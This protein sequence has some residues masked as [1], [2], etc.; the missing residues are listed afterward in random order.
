MQKVRGYLMSQ[1]PEIAPMLDYAEE[2]DDEELTFEM[3][4]HESN[5]YRWMTETN[6]MTLAVKLW[7]WLNVALVEKGHAYFEPATGL[8]GFDGWRRI[9]HQIHQGAKVHRGTLRRAAKNM[10][11][12]VHINKAE[13]IEP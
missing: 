13:D 4:Q 11:N 3:L 7:G 8:N 9:V 5:S 12:I 1:C 2:Q 6:V 10:P